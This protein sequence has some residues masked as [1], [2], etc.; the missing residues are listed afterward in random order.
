MLPAV[1]AVGFVLAVALLI[2]HRFPCRDADRLLNALHDELAEHPARAAC[3]VAGVRDEHGVL[4]Q[5]V[6]PNPFRQWVAGCRPAASTVVLLE[7][8]QPRLQ[9]AAGVREDAL[10]DVRQHGGGLAARWQD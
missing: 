3:T 8:V 7:V 5:P 6:Q 10:V 4:R 9:E 2:A 1:A